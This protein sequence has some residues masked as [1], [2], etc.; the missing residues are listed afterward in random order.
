MPTESDTKP[1]EKTYMIPRNLEIS[2]ITKVYQE[3]LKFVSETYNK[4]VLDAGDVALIDTA[5][6][7]FLVQFVTKLRSSGCEVLWINDS[8]QIYQMAEE[9]GMAEI[10][11]S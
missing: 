6:V 7:Q 8:V 4:V 9:L 10:L 1:L 3:A 2:D 11:D 5:G